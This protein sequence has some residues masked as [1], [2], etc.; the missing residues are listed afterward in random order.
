MLCGKFS[1]RPG[2]RCRY[3]TG[4]LSMKR[5]ASRILLGLLAILSL[6]GAAFWFG[7]MRQDESQCLICHRERVENWVCGAKL[8]DEITQNEYSQWVDTFT[9]AEH[10]HVWMRHTGYNRAHWFGRKAIACGGIPTIPRI[11]EQRNSLG[12]KQA[13]KLAAIFHE[14]VKAKSAQS[15]LESFTTKVVEDPQSLLEPGTRN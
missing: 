15:K 11:F 13:Q 7:P 14:L 3:P 12:E 4:R 2:E 1:P 9:P 6:V 8:N 10:Q 5:T